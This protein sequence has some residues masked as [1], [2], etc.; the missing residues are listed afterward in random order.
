MRTCYESC[1]GGSPAFL[2]AQDGLLSPKITPWLWRLADEECVQ[3]MRVSDSLQQQ[4]LLAITGLAD[5]LAE[6]DPKVLG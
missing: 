3:G 5:T 2:R 6:T 4:V 1:V